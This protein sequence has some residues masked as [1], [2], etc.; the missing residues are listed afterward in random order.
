M[1]DPARSDH[2]VLSHDPGEH[3][4]NLRY[5]DWAP[6]D[7]TGDQAHILEDRPGPRQSFLRY[8]KTWRR[9]R[10]R[11]LSALGILLALLFLAI[12]IL[13]VSRAAPAGLTLAVG[14]PTSEWTAQI[15]TPGIPWVREK[16][17][18]AVPTPCPALAQ[19]RLGS[20][21]RSQQHVIGEDQSDY[22]TAPIPILDEPKML[23]D[24]Y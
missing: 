11:C 23:P 13:V 24:R 10:D 1:I 14:F 22:R 4:Q 18:P 5:S 9:G 21:N 2:A 20:D 7:Q 15:L 6:F 17:D 12:L 19:L 3:L 8:R 16:E